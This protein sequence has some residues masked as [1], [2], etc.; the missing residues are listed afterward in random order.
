MR[1]TTASSC[2][3]MCACVCVYQGIDMLVECGEIEEK[4]A[5]AVA[6]YLHTVREHEQK[7]GDRESVCACVCACV[8]V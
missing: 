4:T 1:E 2:K 3:H 7:Q 6:L 5:E 8:C